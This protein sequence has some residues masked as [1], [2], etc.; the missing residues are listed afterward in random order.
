MNAFISFGFYDIREQELVRSP[1]VLRYLYKMAAKCI[2]RCPGITL[3]GILFT[4]YLD[5]PD[6]DVPAYS[7]KGM[8][9]SLAEIGTAREV[10]GEEAQSGWTL[11]LRPGQGEIFRHRVRQFHDELLSVEESVAI[12][13]ISYTSLSHPMWNTMISNKRFYASSSI[14]QPRTG[15]VRARRMHDACPE[16]WEATEESGMA[17]G[18]Q[19]LKE[20][21]CD[22][23]ALYAV[24]IGDLPAALEELPKGECVPCTIREADDN[25]LMRLPVF[26]VSREQIP[27]VAVLEKVL[28]TLS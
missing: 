25:L 13:T 21:H 9:R 4:Q 26:Q 28:N 24:R 19:H 22:D 27:D 17:N 5:L 20:L 15:P 23:M 12:S 16:L 6:L 18:S 10:L 2:Q 8:D 1:Q 11:F 14:R 3:N 7:M